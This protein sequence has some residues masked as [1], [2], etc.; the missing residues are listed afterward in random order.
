M[1]LSNKTT[2]EH[3]LIR[4]ARL[5]DWSGLA[6]FVQA[7]ADK[8]ASD[9]QLEAV[10]MLLLSRWYGMG[11]A[12]LLDACHDRISFR[13]FLG[14][15]PTED[16]DDARLVEAYRRYSA[17]APV[18]VQNI[19]H[20]AEA[21]V[22]AAGYTIKPG[23]AAEAEAIPIAGM[24]SDGTAT[25]EPREHDAGLPKSFPG[26]HEPYV[27]PAS[28]IPLGDEDGLE[29]A[30]FRETLLFQPGELADLLREGE[31]AFARGG[32]HVAASPAYQPRTENLTPLPVREIPPVHASI[33]WPWGSSMELTETLKV[34]RDQKFCR[35]AAELQPY[36]HVS[37][38]HAELAPC[39]EGVWVRDLKSRN[40]TFVNGEQIPSGQ[41][42]L[43][44]ADAAVRFGPHCVLQLRLKRND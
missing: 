15:S 26:V 33:E 7:I 21:Q 3:F 27:G 44:D 32:A 40:G 41:A 37:R 31:S 18:E 17:L 8:T 35:F 30:Q 16:I 34:G 5:I 36:L 6:P 22:L 13:R 42:V 43:V 28:A 12:Q 24:S 10:K 23:V 2:S 11:E 1:D 20:A 38:Q 39:P 25:A 4:V 14:L 9:T 29:P 19:V